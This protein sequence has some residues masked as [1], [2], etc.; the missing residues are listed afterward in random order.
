MQIQE[1][2]VEELGHAEEATY[3]FLDASSSYFLGRATV[4]A[5]MA[6]HMTVQDFR[7]TIRLLDLKF[8]YDVLFAGLFL[9]ES[10]LNMASL[11]SPRDA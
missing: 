10:G 2:I 11:C 6:K 4:A 1:E 7:H 5:K 3:S 9:C 8:Y